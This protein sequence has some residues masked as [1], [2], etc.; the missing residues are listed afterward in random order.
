MID[1]FKAFQSHSTES[2]LKYIDYTIEKWNLSKS[3]AEAFN[4]FRDYYNQTRNPLDLYVLMCYS[5]NYQFRFNSN[6][7]YNS[8]FGKNLSSFNNVMRSNLIKTL[9]RLKDVEFS[10]KQFQDFDYGVLSK[11]S[12]LYADPPYLIA[13]GPYNDG[14]RGFIRWNEKEERMLYSILTD[15]DKSGI[16]FALSN[17]IEHK[18]ERNDILTDWLI[19]NNYNVH[20][21]EFNYKNSSY[22]GKHKENTT[23]EVLITNY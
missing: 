3:N 11:G 18:G 9:D 22:H 13:C 6:H 23:R 15:M 5:F 20:D 14:K 8:S 2:I 1:I 16:K 7:D 21:I 19:K 17:V 10:S 12:F 4:R